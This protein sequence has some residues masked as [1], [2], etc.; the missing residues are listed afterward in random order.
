[1]SP[2]ERLLRQ[3]LASSALTPVVLNRDALRK[4]QR[5][6]VKLIK[7][8][9]E[10]GKPSGLILALEPGAGK[11]VSF[12]TAARDLLDEGL[13]KK[14]LIIAPLLVANTVW[15]AE[16][17]EWAH[18]KGTTYSICTGTE[19]QRIA[20]LEK[21]AEVY[22]INKEN[23]PWLWDYLG[24]GDN[25]DFDF[26]GIDEASMLKN[27]KKRTKL[28][29]LTRFGV[30]AAARKHIKGLVELTGTPSPNG[31][32]NLWGLAYIA[33]QG[34]RL[35][36]TKSSFMERWFD[37]NKYT[38]EVK[39]KPYAEEQILS[40]LGDIMFSL[41]PRDYAELPPMVPN[42]IR[43][44]LPPKV[45][46]EY[47]RFKRT[48]VSEQ[49]DVEAV[50]AA[51]LTNKLLQFCIAKD[52]DVLTGRGWIPIQ[53]VEKTDVVWDGEEWV[54]QR[55][56]IHKGNKN[57][58][59]CYGVQMTVDHKVL[60]VEGWREA[61]DVIYGDASIRL[62]RAEVRLPNCHVETR[63]HFRQNKMR[64]VDVPVSVWDAGSASESV[65]SNSSSSDSDAELWLQARG[66]SESRKRLSRNDW[67]APVG[68]L[69][70][71]QA[72][73]PQSERQGLSQLRSPWHRHAGLLVQIL[74]SLLGRR[75]S[76]IFRRSHFGS[77]EQR[78]R[79][80]EVELPMG[81]EQGPTSQYESERDYRHPL[82][83]N[84][85]GGSCGTRGS[86]LHM[87]VS[88]TSQG[89][90]G[91]GSVLESGGQRTLDQKNGRG[92]L[93]VYDLIDCG[94][95]H[96]FVVRGT[97]GP[98]IVHN[99]NGS[100]FQEDGNDI[101]VHDCKLDALENLHNEVGG[102]PMLVAYSYKFDKRRIKE[103]FKHAVILNEVPDV[104]QTVRDWNAG[105]I[106]MLLAHPAS[107]AH[108]LNIQKGS[109]ISCWYGLNSDLELFQQF[110]K[111]LHRPG[112]I[113]DIVWS[114]R[115]IA[116]GTHDEDILPILDDKK[117]VQDRVFEATK[118]TLND[119]DA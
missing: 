84:D 21:N 95:R 96:R 37:F 110:N 64:N 44:K 112:Q 47:R 108:G 114:H 48:L 109:N 11:T 86:V 20:A 117:S 85:L 113:A 91:E 32:V 49:Y 51:V 82:G 61:Q 68:D 62:D 104:M 13:I 71:P 10:S 29:K 35:G 41:D 15:H 3:Y 36:R 43:V 98:V 23:L 56:S 101:W 2:W 33:D 77:Q 97:D 79:L 45:M 4:Y 99:C 75:S 12:L 39:A 105:K 58:V 5:V 46:D 24:R 89:V 18:L 102:T 115:I 67:R 40:A 70:R 38:Y 111:R 19:K 69:A 30:L 1:M 119:F 116:V 94:P 65:P 87:H 88:A 80:F 72:Q 42:E 27:G 52:T 22:I 17:E 59:S 92:A 103:K 55:G 90:F 60:T 76:G 9:L 74:R 31:L 106:D 26:V 6:S 16:I 53:L 28:K 25:W 57:V 66:D 73:M 78:Q 8:T 93:A 83:Q 34:A 100:L 50:N 14:V 63:E 54:K 107:A 81:Y 7:D 118:L